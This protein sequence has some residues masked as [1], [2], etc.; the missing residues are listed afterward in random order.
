VR[1]RPWSEWRV[2]PRRGIR[3]GKMPVSGMADK[4]GVICEASRR[5]T[6]LAIVGKPCLFPPPGFRFF[7]AREGVCLQL[8]RQRA[9]RAHLHS[10]ARLDAVRSG[11][12]AI[13]E[14]EIS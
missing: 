4:A 14:C 7:A 5:Q 3:R 12:R 10:V 8:D 9:A 6:R 13:T 1:P 11:G 2:I